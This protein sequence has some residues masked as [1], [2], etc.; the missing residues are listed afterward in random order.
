M[1]LRKQTLVFLTLS[2]LCLLIV[3]IIA[4]SNIFLQGFSQVEQT[5]IEND[6][7]LAADFLNEDIASL[8][9]VQQDWANWDDA[10]KYASDGNDDFVQ[11]NLNDATIVRLN[12]RF[13]VLLK[14]DNTLVFGRSIDPRTKNI[15]PLPDEFTSYLASSSGR[16]LLTGAG[17][18]A[19]NHIVSGIFLLPRL[20]D[21]L[22][23]VSSPILTSDNQGPS[24]GT[25]IMVR[26]LDESELQNLSTRLHFPLQIESYDSPTLSADFQKARASINTTA[27][28]PVYIEALDDDT[29]RG[30]MVLKDI[31][32]SPALLIQMEVPRQIYKQGQNTLNYLSILIVAVFVIFGALTLFLMEKM[33]LRRISDLKKEVKGV[34]ISG[35]LT[36]RVTVKGNDEIATLAQVTNQMLAALEQSRANERESENRFRLLIEKLPV[37]VT[38]H[39]PAARVQ[40]ANQAAADL[41]GLPLIQLIG[42]NYYASDW[43]CIHEDGTDFPE[44]LRPVQQAIGTKKPVRN[45][46]MG[47]HRPL[48]DSWAWL[49]VNAEPFL[50]NTGKLTNIICTLNDVTERRKVDELKSE[51]VSVVSHEL[52]TPLTSIFG[53]LGLLIGGVAG[54][55]PPVARSMLEVAYKNSDRLVKLINDILDIEKIE[56][57]KM[58]LHKKQLE[59]APLLEQV[60]ASTRSYAD[61][62]NVVIE[63]DKGDR[64]CVVLTDGDRLTQ[65]LVNIISNAAKF[66]PPGGIV[67]VA[68]DCADGKRAL[69]SVTD[70]GGGISEEFQG[71]IF[72]KFAQAD[73]SSTRQKGG[74]GLGLSISRAIMERLKGN[75]TYTSVV[76]EGTTF[77]IELPLYNLGD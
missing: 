40:L 29:N 62:Y 68:L 26:S 60:V 7:K 2:L 77:Y 17:A 1:T 31:S 10:Y 38:L 49:L 54:E 63:L 48:N 70:R 22:L 27:S 76:G 51:F 66:S 45:V 72:Q 12:L 34:G 32:G 47:V 16:L 55:I 25:L 44:E 52:R 28:L 11:A 39:D 37:G 59:L 53:S 67:N 8:T 50:D 15:S 73:S 33:L 61:Q 41:L 43:Q 57:G 30:Y 5:T 21:P 19:A 13:F 71:Q 20:D 36:T 74:T 35:N 56:A 65:V 18:N 14:P 64:N 9:Q 4:T 6:L 3:L 24:H 58:T 75:L 42:K 23:V 69:I 46:M